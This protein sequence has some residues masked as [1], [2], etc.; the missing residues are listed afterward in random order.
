M[1]SIVGPVKITS[2][3]SGGQVNFGDILNVS[4]KSNSK[5]YA[6]SGSFGT[7][8]VHFYNDWVSS[9]NTL[10]SDVTDETIAANN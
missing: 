2:V 7:G 3:G 10:D 8:D 1:P 9:T 4:P 5:T 6:G